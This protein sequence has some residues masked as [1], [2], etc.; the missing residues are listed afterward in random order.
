M[1]L[2]MSCFAEDVKQPNVAGAFYPD[3]PV[4]LSEMIDK[5]LQD[6]NPQTLEGEIFALIS[7]H[8]GYDFS[9]S[10]AAY[11]YK[12]IK[13]RG[14]KTVVIIGPSHYSGFYG[15][16]V[17]PQGAFRT[18][19]GDV[20]IDAE[21]T[22]KLIDATADIKFIPQAFQREHSVEVQ[23]PFLQK[24]L[25]AFKIVP[26]IMGQVDFGLCQELANRL[27]SLIGNRKDVLVIA[28]TD[29]YHGY[30]YDEAEAI[31][32]FTLSVL[33][34][35]NPQKLYNKISEGTAQ[36]CGGNGV[37]VTMLTAKGLGHNKLKVLKYA[38][39]AQITNRKVKG[40]WTVG[41]TSCVIDRE[42]GEE[43]MLNKDQRKRLL[44]IA[45]NSIDTYLKTGKK[46]ELTEQDPVLNKKMGAFVTLHERGELRGCIG[47]LVGSQPLY[48][49]VRDMAVEAAVGDPRFPPVK[50]E[51]LKDIAIEISALSELER[52][53]DP[54][55]IE[56][57]VH[58]VL[59]RR[60]FNSGVFLPQ[61][62]TETG[63]AKEEFLSNLCSHK[64]GLS[65][66]AWK[67]K[68]TEIYV[69]TAEVFSEND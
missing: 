42:K 68:A 41:Y 18:P 36:F 17:Y 22:G 35:M 20:F 5:C 34:E 25:T 12:L 55:S 7:P 59:V 10:V 65:A 66:D 63:W 52:I 27:V 15:I 40:V 1:L 16:S 26:I 37:V 8:A 9:G 64:A 47:N 67:D 23:I 28:S 45:R 43:A 44:G 33:E 38:N 32:R 30:D 39:S 19:L 57:G 49:T 62:A 11:G 13:N 50:K 2:T 6:A 29:M 60:G 4:V 56:L 21:F 3:N 46:L 51:E 14:Y 58:G 31:D 48:L 61:V 24:A 53:A 54:L 69:F